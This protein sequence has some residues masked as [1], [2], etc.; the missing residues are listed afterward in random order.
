MSF[1]SLKQ[2]YWLYK[3]KP[4]A[5]RQ[6]ASVYGVPK[7]WH[8]YKNKQENVHKSWKEILKDRENE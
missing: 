2:A 5:F 8:D 1:K 6:I 3:N 4:S 7:G